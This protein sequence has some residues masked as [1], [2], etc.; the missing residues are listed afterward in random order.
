MGASLSDDVIGIKILFGKLLQGTSGL[1]MIC[2]D[3]DLIANFEVWCQRLVFVGGE[4]VL[5]LSV[6]DG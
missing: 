6:R 5:F 4:L 3:K 1:E 2:F